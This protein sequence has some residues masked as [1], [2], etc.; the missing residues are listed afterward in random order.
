MALLRYIVFSLPLLA[1]MALWWLRTEVREAPVERTG[2]AMVCLIREEVGPLNPLVPLTGVEREIT[3]MLFERLLVRDEELVLQPNLIESWEYHTLVT[4]HC[5]SEE[6]GGEF[7]ARLRA[8]EYG[9]EGDPSC[10]EIVRE[11]A[12]VTV[13]FDGLH[14]GWAEEF[15]GRIDPGLLANFTLVRLRVKNSVRPSFEAFLRDSVERSQIRMIDYEGDRTVNVFTEGETDL[16]LREL[17][18]YYESNRGLEPE[19]EEAGDVSHTSSLELI[20]RLR[21][22]VQWHDGPYLTADDVL[23]SYRELTR[24]GSPYSVA[25]SFW[26]V[27]GIEKMDRLS[28]R[29]TC[30]QRPGFHLESWEKLP[31]LPA[32]L[33]DG[34]TPERWLSFFENPVGNGPYRLEGRRADGG[35]EL[36]AHEGYF[37][38]APRQRYIVYERL[39]DQSERLMRLRLGRFETVEAE[40]REWQWARRNPSAIEEIRCVPRFQNF[41]AWNLEDPFLSQREVRRALACVIDPARTLEDGPRYYQVRTD[42]LFFPGV[43]YAGEPMFLPEFD[44]AM[45]ER[46]MV[47]AGYRRDEASGAI[48]HRSGA[49]VRLTLTVNRENAEQQSLAQRISTQWREFGIDVILESVSWEEIV[50]EKLANRRFDGILLGW[51]LPYERDRYATWHSSQVE[52][53]GGNFCG[54]RNEEVDEW[55]E[56]LRSETDAERSRIAAAELQKEIADWQPYLFL[57]NTGRVMRL[58]AGALTYAPEGRLPGMDEPPGVRPSRAGLDRVRPWWVRRDI[59]TSGITRAE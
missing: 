32:H 21:G 45:A 38:G 36:A 34:A 4:V 18:L 33:L 6:A 15:V 13:S 12:V 41:V 46:L 35:F 3:D 27:E 52:A 51:E 24:P 59:T 37:R 30:R 42:S 28:L 47:E 16:F 43:P 44:L 10:R 1:A 7:E 14:D 23:F 8:E 48:V 5:E 40:L 9:R 25:S 55:L 11:G 49:P 50:T 2:D 39:E 57:C 26:F 19:I 54:F 20:V 58:R 53:G 31:V 29:V 56:T 22:D 17:R